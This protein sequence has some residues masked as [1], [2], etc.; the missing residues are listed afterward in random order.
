MR[1]A[2]GVGAD[3]DPA[4][5][6]ARQLG[7]GQPGCL[8]VIGGRVRPGAA[9]PQHDREGFPVPGRA[10][11]GEGAQ[12]VEAEGLLPSRRGLL[13]LRVG[14]H[15]RGVQVDGDQPAIRAWR[16]LPGQRPR[17][18][19]RRRTGGPDGLQRPRQVGGQ[20]ADQPGHHRVGRD[21]PGQLRLLPQHRDVGQAVPAQGDRGGQVRNDLARVVDRPRRPPPGK[22]RRQAPAQAGHPH[23]LP[24]QH[25]P[26]LRHQAPAVSRHRDASSTC[27]ILHGKS[28]FDS[29]LIGP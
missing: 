13:F 20:R 18:L 27:T 22:A 19:A 6:A 2:G 5:Q 21:R 17:P 12:R 24:Q 25:G 10:V 23:R 15:D 4:A 8:D 16:V 29:W 14:D 1:A 9:C 28:A 7:Q 3:Q 26:G 11:V